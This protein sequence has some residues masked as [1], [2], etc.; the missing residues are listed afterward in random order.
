MSGHVL[1]SNNVFTLCPGELITVVEERSY[2]GDKLLHLTF[3]TEEGML[4]LVAFNLIGYE[5]HDY[6]EPL[7][8]GGGIPEKPP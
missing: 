1:V 3:L 5:L 7:E 2:R 8:I 4:V 6:I